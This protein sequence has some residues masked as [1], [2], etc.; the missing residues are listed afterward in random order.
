[1]QPDDDV[2]LASISAFDLVPD[3]ELEIGY[4]AHPDARG[5]GVMTRAMAVVLRYGFEDLGVRRIHAA[6]AAGLA[7][8]VSHQSA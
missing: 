3:E 7:A 1:M 5:R 8:A 2:A 4:W 6:A